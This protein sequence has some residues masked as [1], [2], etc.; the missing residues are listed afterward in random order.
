VFG[1]AT[2]GFTTTVFF[3]TQAQLIG[4]AGQCVAPNATRTLNGSVTGLGA[5]DQV[6]IAM[7]GGSANASTATSLTFQLENVLNGPSDLI[8]VRN[9]FTLGPPP[10][11]TPLGVI[12]RRG[13]NIADQGTIP[14]LDFG[15]AEAFAPQTAAITLANLGG[16]TPIVT[17]GYQTPTTVAGLSTSLSGGTAHTVH[18]IPAARQD[19]TDLHQLTAL[20]AAGQ[21]GD[22]RGHLMW[23]K[24]L[25]DKTVTLGPVLTAPTIA[26]LGNAPYPRYSSSGPIQAEYDDGFSLV[27]TQVAGTGRAWSITATRGYFAA[28]TYTLL[29]PD[30]S[31]A[32]YLAL[33]ALQVGAQATLNTSAYG[34][35]GNG[36]TQP[37]VE[38]GFGDFA[39]RI[40]TVTP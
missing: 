32:G 37:Q 26:S 18:G 40:G 21:A 17:L 33:W 30:M 2:D 15:A 8:A 35:S 7:G 12:I 22:A 31:A 13:L 11:L 23:F 39:T 38:G 3:G 1:D 14:V 6:S 24:T 28:A 16:D 29:M 34:F 10:A 36:F 25:A 20:A 5:T 4:T 27:A 19:A 9:S